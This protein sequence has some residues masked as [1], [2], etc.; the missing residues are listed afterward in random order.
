MIR[1]ARYRASTLTLLTTRNLDNF[2]ATQQT[3]LSALG[4]EFGEVFDIDVGL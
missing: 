2:V 3:S 4:E 1:T